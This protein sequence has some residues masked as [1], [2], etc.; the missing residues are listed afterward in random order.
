MNAAAS[1]EAGATS[2]LTA[3]AATARGEVALAGGGWVTT[4]AA[5]NEWCIH[6]YV[7]Q[8]ST[9]DH[10]CCSTQRWEASQQGVRC[11]PPLPLTRAHARAPL[12]INVIPVACF[13]LNSPEQ[14]V[15]SRTPEVR[16]CTHHVSDK[17]ARGKHAHGVCEGGALHP[18][19]MSATS[20]WGR[21]RHLGPRALQQL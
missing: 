20:H 13:R 1:I 18:R 7:L 15:V 6:V 9:S 21:L 10:T 5:A 19:C 17:G 12:T 11:S 14:G 8:W 4:C 2:P 16:W 3:R